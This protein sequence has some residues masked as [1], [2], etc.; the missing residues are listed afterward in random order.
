MISVFPCSSP[1]CQVRSLLPAAGPT[2]RR[3]LPALTS[4]CATTACTRGTWPS[5][6]LP[7]EQREEEEDK[8]EGDNMLCQLVE[9]DVWSLVSGYGAM[10]D[11]RR[12]WAQLM[13]LSATR[14]QENRLTDDPQ[15]LQNAPQLA[16]ILVIWHK[17]SERVQ[18]HSHSEP[19]RRTEYE[20]MLIHYFGYFSTL[21]LASC[22]I[23]KKCVTFK[24][25]W[26]V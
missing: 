18:Y 3:S 10:P 23:V 4:W 7:S 17:D 11:L 13:P 25:C 5:C 2:V 15:D 20:E 8:E 21:A 9:K 19:R 26:I 12:W 16:L 14:L 24:M 1:P 6:S 22:F